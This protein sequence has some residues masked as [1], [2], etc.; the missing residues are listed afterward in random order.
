MRGEDGKAPFG[1]EQVAQEGV[2]AAERLAAFLGRR[3]V[4]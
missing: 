1:P 3:V 2:R 4:V